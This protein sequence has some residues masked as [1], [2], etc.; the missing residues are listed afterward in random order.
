MW[1]AR[2]HLSSD[3]DYPNASEEI[4]CLSFV[5]HEIPRLLSD[6]EVSGVSCLLWLV[7]PDLTR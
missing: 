6:D 1:D 2:K 4:R 7:L 3:G 5:F